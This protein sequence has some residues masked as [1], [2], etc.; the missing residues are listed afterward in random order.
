MYQGMYR[1]YR[2]DSP[3]TH[4]LEDIFNLKGILNELRGIGIQTGYC[5]CIPLQS[6]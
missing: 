5:V 6:L 4:P 2:Q 3:I 1:T